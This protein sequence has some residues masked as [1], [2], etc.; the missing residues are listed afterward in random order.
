MG[1]VLLCIATPYILLPFGSILH[2]SF[3]LTGFTSNI[4]RND[5]YHVYNGI[6][7]PCDILGIINNRDVHDSSTTQQCVEPNRWS[8]RPYR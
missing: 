4:N 2:H 7:V 6:G 1:T 5:D 8:Y 3:S